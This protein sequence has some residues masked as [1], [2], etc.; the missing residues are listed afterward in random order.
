[1][2]YPNGGYDQNYGG[3]APYGNDPYGQG[4][5][6]QPGYPGSQGSANSYGQYPGSAGSANSYGQYPGSAGSANSYGDYGQGGY[7]QQQSGYGQQG[8]YG[9]PDAYGQ[10]TYGQNTHG[11]DPY[12]QPGGYQSG[13]AY[14]EPSGIVGPYGSVSPYGAG[15][16]GASQ[17]PSVSFVEAFKL[18]FKNYAN[19]YGRAS[20][21]EY[22]W[23]ALGMGGVMAV[24]YILM[25]VMIAASA[26]SMESGDL[27]GGAMAIY[28][29]M[30]LIGLA[31][32]VPNLALTVRR[33]HDS[34]KS[35][36]FYLISLIPFG[37][38]VLLVFL[39]GE[40][41]PNGA[42]FDNPDG[43]QPVGKEAL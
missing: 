43:S 32:L 26:G 23:V 7:G 16:Y 35:G 9:Q 36:W 25:M 28:G 38:I 24:L 33:L 4:G 1:M 39:A 42:R 37:S 34:D 18:F 6:N 20:R 41:N 40:S 19:F 2:S 14:P 8:G 3:N 29:I 22:W 17:R 11:Q 5:A 21:S 12:G 10:N 31:T 15:P 13:G 27:P 30:M